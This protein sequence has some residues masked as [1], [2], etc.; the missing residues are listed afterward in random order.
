MRSIPAESDPTMSFKAK[1]SLPLFILTR[2]ISPEC[3]KL[4]VATWTERGN[5]FFSY[6]FYYF[7]LDN[8]KSVDL[9]QILKLIIGFDTFLIQHKL[10][11]IF[12]ASTVRFIGLAT[13]IGGFLFNRV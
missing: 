1:E 2:D 13:E 3:L 11:V 6:D 10:V 7:C 12:G 8:G 4:I 9:S 5:F